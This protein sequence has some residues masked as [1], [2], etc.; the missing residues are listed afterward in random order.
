MSP[1]PVTSAPHGADAEIFRK[2]ELVR[3]C[4]D[5]GVIVGPSLRGKGPKDL[6]RQ[7]IMAGIPTYLIASEAAEPKRLKEG[8]GKLH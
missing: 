4:A 6:A 7:A 5:L 1:P 8:D 3:A 2:R